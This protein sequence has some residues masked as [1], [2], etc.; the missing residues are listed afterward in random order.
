MEHVSL[1][2]DLAI[3]KT[4]GIPLLDNSLDFGESC[5]EVSN[6]LSD[7]VWHWKMLPNRIC[8]TWKVHEWKLK[9]VIY[10]R[11]LQWTSKC[12]YVIKKCYESSPLRTLVEL[13][14]VDCTLSLGVSCWLLLAAGHGGANAP[15]SASKRWLWVIHDI[16]TSYERVFVLLPNWYQILWHLSQGSLDNWNSQRLANI[17]IAVVLLQVQKQTIFSKDDPTFNRFIK[18]SQGNDSY[19][20]S[21]YINSFSQR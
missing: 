7:F 2:R 3:R 12:I 15:M 14:Q 13:M 18:L 17:L 6:C 8:G 19:Y 1:R 9:S 16:F 11:N 21:I 10:P 20:C 5:L 4:V